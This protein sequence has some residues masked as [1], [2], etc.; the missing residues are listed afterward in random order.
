MLCNGHS[1]IRCKVRQTCISGLPLKENS[2]D[3]CLWTTF[4]VAV[5]FSDTGGLCGVFWKIC[6]TTLFLLASGISPINTSQLEVLLLGNSCRCGIT[7]SVDMCEM[8]TCEV[9]T[10]PLAP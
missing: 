10:G 6:G 2:P 3:T 9:A 5:G 8:C 7:I 1:P 4:Y